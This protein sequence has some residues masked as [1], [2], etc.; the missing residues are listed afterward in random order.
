MLYHIEADVDK[1]DLNVVQDV[2][3]EPVDVPNV[4]ALAVRLNTW[5]LRHRAGGPRAE[6]RQCGFEHFFLPMRLILKV[7][8]RPINLLPRFW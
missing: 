5:L 7:K 2:A 6:S 8:S 1:A 4:I 3:Q